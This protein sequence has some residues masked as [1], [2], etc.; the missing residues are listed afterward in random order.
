MVILQYDRIFFARISRQRRRDHERAAEIAAIPMSI[1]RMF[2]QQ[3]REHPVKRDD[4]CPIRFCPEELL[5]NRH[6]DDA[7]N[8]DDALKIRRFSANEAIGTNVVYPRLGP[9]HLC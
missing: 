3:E 5:V 7:D 6:R 8:A 2:L 9:V 1:F 4:A